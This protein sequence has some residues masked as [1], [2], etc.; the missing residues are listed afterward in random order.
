MP[1]IPFNSKQV[2]LKLEEKSYLL[3]QEFL[4]AWSHNHA[5]RPLNRPFLMINY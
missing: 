3:D 4:E 5:T 2:L 1:C